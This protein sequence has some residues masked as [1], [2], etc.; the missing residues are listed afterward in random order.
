MTAESSMQFWIEHLRVLAAPL[1]VVH[2]GAGSSTTSLHYA[3][4]SVPR[5]LLVEADERLHEKLE[6]ATADRPGWS[7]HNSLVD[8]CDGESLFHVA[9]NPRESGLVP[10]ENLNVLWRNLKTTDRRTLPARSL[11]SLLSESDISTEEVNWAVVDC[12]PAL[13]ILRGAGRYLGSLDVIRVRTLMDQEACSIVGASISEISEFLESHG[14]RCVATDAERQPAIGSALFARN[15][16]P[17][18][19]QYQVEN[20]RT[21]TE[22]LSHKAALRAATERLDQEDASRAVQEQLLVERTEQLERLR[23]EKDSAEELLTELRRQNAELIQQHQTALKEAAERSLELEQLRVSK[24]SIEQDSAQLRRQNAELIQ[25][26]QTALKEA[27]ERSLELE[28]LRVSKESI[29]QDSAQLRRQNAELVQQHESALNEAAKRSAELEQAIKAR[30]GALQRVAELQRDFAAKLPRI[31]ELAQLRE[32]NSSLAN[33]ASTLRNAQQ[34]LASEKAEQTAA[35]EQ[36]ARH[37][38]ES[39]EQI[40]TLNHAKT[41]AERLVTETQNKLRALSATHEELKKQ[42]EEQRREATDARRTAAL[43]VKLQSLRE[44]ALQDLQTRH[45]DL[46]INYESQQD[47]LEKLS[48]RLAAVADYLHQI[49]QP[50][51]LVLST[52]TPPADTESHREQRSSR[53]TSLGNNG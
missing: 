23:A 31:E 5:V 15:W 19:R 28:Q 1:G 52:Q 49:P 11:E 37:A 45:R 7:S 6:V 46:R 33:E 41:E 20:A 53:V 14:F 4:W 22:L 27:A 10:P 2:V 34:A 47:L 48:V 26:H 35:L 17:V 8:E 13:P 32:A 30:D 44:S 16:K 51:E 21:A 12:L 43:S 42:F 9:T 50:Q 39:A 25:Q 36:Q 18:V 29:E 3:Q 40:K 24:E 38:A